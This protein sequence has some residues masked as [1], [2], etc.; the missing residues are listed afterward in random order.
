MEVFQFL[1]SCLMQSSKH[2]ISKGYLWISLHCI[3]QNTDCFREVML[4]AVSAK[5]TSKHMFSWFHLLYDFSDWKWVI[6]FRYTLQF[7]QIG[8]I[9]S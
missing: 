4:F 5:Q 8:P 3:E 6:F 2:S 9:D 7:L 1:V